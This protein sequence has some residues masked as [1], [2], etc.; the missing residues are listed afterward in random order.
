MKIRR[1]KSQVDRLPASTKFRKQSLKKFL[2][3][4]HRSLLRLQAEPARTETYNQGNLPQTIKR[5]LIQQGTATMQTR[6][7]L[8]AL[9]ATQYIASN[10]QSK[11]FVANKVKQDDRLDSSAI[12]C[13]AHNEVAKWQDIA[14]NA[15]GKYRILVAE[16][17][18]Y[19]KKCGGI[20]ALASRR[21]SKCTARGFALR[22]CEVS[23]AEIEKAIV[24]ETSTNYAAAI[25]GS[26]LP[27]CVATGKKLLYK[28]QE[29]HLLGHSLNMLKFEL[30][31]KHGPQIKHDLIG[32]ENN[33]GYEDKV[34]E[35]S[36]SEKY[37]TTK[38]CTLAA[39]INTVQNVAESE[40]PPPTQ[41][42]VDVQ[43]SVITSTTTSPIPKRPSH[44]M[45]YKFTA[46]DSETDHKLAKERD[47]L[48]RYCM[49][50]Q[51]QMNALAVAD[52]LW[53][54]QQSLASCSSAQTSLV[55]QRLADYRHLQDKTIK[56]KVSSSLQSF[57]KN[58]SRETCEQHNSWG[59]FTAN[60]EDGVSNNILLR[61][62]EELEFKKF[63]THKLIALKLAEI[64][65]V[66][67]LANVNR[68]QT[69]NMSNIEVKTPPSQ[70]AIF[71]FIQAVCSH[72]TQLGETHLLRINLSALRL[73]DH[74]ITNILGELGAYIAC[75]GPPF[76]HSAL[77]KTR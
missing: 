64:L 34:C 4:A 3:N 39:K 6:F 76:M 46:L 1:S 17:S 58:A 16:F 50:L 7:W 57:I 20:L 23:A 22:T 32:W 69:E 26:G 45:H 71:R 68:N 29:S 77:A 10:Q 65:R 28:R 40:T 43:A 51:H 42:R 53:R 8:T 72:S 74:V 66:L 31:G 70:E 36:L 37:H 12:M 38:K 30:L 56:T 47:C 33:K 18:G 49:F 67:Y 48:A 44:K 19:R 13:Q 27:R 61:T 25:Q 75:E 35:K 5:V 63:L 55:A 52:V 73:K 41:I 62:V 60:L 54:Q 21:S 24:I 14:R 9:N 15:S 2:D 59:Y 11:V